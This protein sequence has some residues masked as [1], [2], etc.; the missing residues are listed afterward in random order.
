MLSAT[1]VNNRFND[2]RNQLALAYEGQS[3][4]LSRNLK[5]N[6]GI[7]EIFRRAQKAFNTWSELQPQERTAAAI[8]KALDFD[9]FELL[10]A[11][12]IARSRKHIETFYDK[13][14]V[15]FR[16]RQK[17]LSYQC[18]ITNR[19]DVLGFN[20]IFSRLSVLKLAVYAPI[21]YILSSRL[22]KY[23]EIYDTQ[24]EGG[25][26]KLRQADREQSLQ[27]LMT[28]NLLKRL[29]SS[30]EAFRL[31]LRAL[32]G[33]IAQIL[34]AIATFERT[35]G[36]ASVT[37]D[38]GDPGFDADDED[39][40][41]LD[42]FT[43]GRKIQISLAD[44]DLPSWKHD[45]EA[46]LVLI[47]DL[48]ASMDKVGPGDDAKPQH[49]KDVIARKVAEPLNPGNRKVL[50]FTAFADTAKYLYAN[51]APAFLQ[52]EGLNSGLVAGSDA[53]KSTL[54]KSYDFQS[55]DFH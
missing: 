36:S 51:L 34:E 35:G 1:P 41:G 13:D 26:G 9:F 22:P 48:I 45:L 5:T 23:E 27:A 54:K 4:N 24:V 43:V 16:H 42:E 2:L 18:P 29:E 38:L 55:V 6:T 52:S 8:L 11:V 49:L 19:P 12:T 53:P 28:T 15:K 10:D 32:S 46:D 47:R 21:S 20:N 50:I 3:E 17:P 33:N 44:M 39:L 37:D 40:T 14:I 7:E 31:T 30:V 25:R